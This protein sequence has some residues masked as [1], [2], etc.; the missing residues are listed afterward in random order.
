MGI[1]NKGKGEKLVNK[2][3]KKWKNV[4]RKERRGVEAS[5]TVE[6][7]LL[8]PGLLSVF[9]FFLSLLQIV[10]AEQII[11]YTA[12]KV[13]E[14][15]AACGYLLKYSV[16]ET[17]A[18]WKCEGKLFEPARFA[19]DILQGAGNAS[20]FR[21]IMEKRLKEA[22]CI[23]AVV[24]G[25]ISGIDFWGSEVYAEDE[26]AVVCMDFKISFPVFRRFLPKLSFRKNVVVRSFSGLGEFEREEEEDEDEGN[27]DEE[28]TKEGYVYVTESGTVYHRNKSCTYIRLSVER[29]AGGEVGEKRNQYGGKYYPCDSCMRGGE[30]P[31]TVWVTKTGTHCHARKDCSKIKRTVKKIPVS[32]AEDYRPCSRCAKGGIK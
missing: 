15:T 16:E 27:G 17:E 8:L 1:W 18:L 2:K 6:A 11:Y 32:E 9:L 12:A 5:L 23:N 19:F 10:R 20:W 26:M 7:A 30:I 3:R 21:G 29:M 22:E 24:E 28:E 14:E 13:A 25:G 31:E 4:W